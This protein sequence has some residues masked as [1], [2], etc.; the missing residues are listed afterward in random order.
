MK[1]FIGKRSDQFCYSEMPVVFNGDQ[2]LIYTS[3]TIPTLLCFGHSVLVFDPG[4]DTFGRTAMWR[5]LYSHIIKLDIKR[6][7]SNAYNPLFDIRCSDE[8]VEDARLIAQCFETDQTDILAACLL[9][10][11]FADHCNAPT[12][13]S[14]RVMLSEAL[15]EE[16]GQWAMLADVPGTDFIVDALAKPF[17]A[18]EFCRDISTQLL[19]LVTGYAAQN[20]RTSSFDM[21]SLPAH[22]VSLYVDGPALFK[23]IIK[24]QFQRQHNTLIVD[25]R[26]PHLSGAQHLQGSCQSRFVD[27]AGVQY[28]RLDYTDEPFF[29]ARTQYYLP[30]WTHVDDAPAFDNGWAHGSPSSIGPHHK[31]VEVLPQKKVPFFRL[32]SSEL[33]E[34]GL[35]LMSLKQWLV[36]A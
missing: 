10:T 3:I 28:Q 27:V 19:P 4:M 6:S 13:N 26:G 14:L 32:W 33:I 9:Y 34:R 11:L 36:Q 20:M 30:G 5:C 8:C 24:A 31:V 17:D 23:R 29:R 18:T 25:E 12:F 2:D 35:D 21:R 7:N 16:M 22:R 15:F 1:L